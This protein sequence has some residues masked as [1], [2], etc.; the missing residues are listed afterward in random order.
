[1]IL[2]EFHCRCA[3]SLKR[4]SQLP[5]GSDCHVASLMSERLFQ[6]TNSCA[7]ERAVRSLQF[8]ENREVVR[9]GDGKECGWCVLL[10]PRLIQVP[11]IV[12]QC[13]QLCSTKRNG[14]RLVHDWQSQRRKSVDFDVREIECLIE[15]SIAKRLEVIHTGYGEP[16]DDIRVLEVQQCKLRT[17]G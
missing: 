9:A 2:I 10:R 14:E 13:W 6:N 16:S 5:A 1:M 8:A 17:G 7:D 4:W 11:S 15:R 12:N 3:V